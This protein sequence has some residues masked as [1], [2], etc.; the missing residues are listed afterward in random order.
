MSDVSAGG[1]RSRT[2]PGAERRAK[3]ARSGGVGTDLADGLACAKR[4]HTGAN[5]R[6]AS[7]AVLGS[8]TSCRGRA[9]KN[10]ERKTRTARTKLLHKRRILLGRGDCLRAALAVEGRARI[11]FL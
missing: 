2:I 11:P 1:L 8:E 7:N 6:P 4:Q 3:A 9:K 5:R 10:G